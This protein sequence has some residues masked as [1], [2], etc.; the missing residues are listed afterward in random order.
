MDLFQDR[1]TR[2]KE[3]EE[4]RES[5]KLQGEGES[6]SISAYSGYTLFAAGWV[7]YD[8]DWKGGKREQSAGSCWWQI[9]RKG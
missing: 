9:R 7:D 1:A 6:I 8:R 3:L 2:G 5:R 4:R